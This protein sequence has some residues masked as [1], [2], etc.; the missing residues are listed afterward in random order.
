[1][2]KAALKYFISISA[3]VDIIEHLARLR[4]LCERLNKINE[5]DCNE[6]PT[7]AREREEK[8]LVELARKLAGELGCKLHHQGDPRGPAIRLIRPDG[9]SNGMDGETWYL[10]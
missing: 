1:M 5:L 4:K 2:N 7:V 8:R 3:D 10:E 6:Q 9:Q